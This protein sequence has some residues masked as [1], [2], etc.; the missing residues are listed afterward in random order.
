MEETYSD[1]SITGDH[2][3][4]IVAQESIHN[5]LREKWHY[6]DDAIIQVENPSSLCN[7]EI[8]YIG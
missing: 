4:P 1:E 8:P 5:V 3:H 7:T 2:E 6:V